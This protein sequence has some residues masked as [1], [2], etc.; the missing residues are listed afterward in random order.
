M[1]ESI[2]D[3]IS[4]IFY[5]LSDAERRVANGVM[6][7]PARAQYLSITELSELAGVGDA[8]VSRFCR[9]LGFSGFYAFKLELAKALTEKTEERAVG[10]SIGAVLSDA[11]AALN[12][13]A[14]VL[15]EDTVLRA[16]EMICGA[17]RVLCAGAGG[18]LLI[19]AEC[20]HLF[21]T[22]SPKFFAVPDTHMQLITLSSMKADDVLLLVSYSGAT[23]SGLELIGYAKKCGIKTVLLT[24]F[25]RSPL[26]KVADEVLCCAAQEGPYQSGSIPARIAQLLAVDALFRAYCNRNE[27]ANERAKCVAEALSDQH[28]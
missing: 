4:E 10:S 25:A 24:G 2:L 1:T 17:E 15:S 19:A 7:D 12:A 27:T 20:A 18:S 14:Q 3:R 5:Q 6:N 21:S 8:T 13:T 28:L 16:A 23:K 22:V 11:T 26:G 9:R